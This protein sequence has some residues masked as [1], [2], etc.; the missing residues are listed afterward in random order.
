MACRRALCQRAR[1][2][3]T[4]RMLKVEHER[5]LAQ[6][7]QVPVGGCALNTLLSNSMAP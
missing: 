1:Q 2:V 6:L 4:L 3:A 5:E 7:A